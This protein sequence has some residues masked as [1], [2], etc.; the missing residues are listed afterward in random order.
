LIFRCG[1]FVGPGLKKNAI[2][3]I[4]Q[5]GPL[6]LDPES[7]LQFLHTDDAARLALSLA[8][9]GVR[10]EILNLCGSGVVRLADVVEWVGR[11]VTV[12]PG[13]ARVRYDVS[14]EK[15]GRLVE[16]PV[17]RETVRSFVKM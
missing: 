16:V 2:F 6:W 4:L 12:Q 8:Q 15:L 13:S 14:I 10:N 7:E 3:D 17:T 1:G 11:P 9:A 5:G